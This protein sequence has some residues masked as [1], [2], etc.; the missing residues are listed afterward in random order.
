VPMLAELQI[1][2]ASAEITEQRLTGSHSMAL[3]AITHRIYRSES[4]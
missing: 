3:V 2:R 4:R 1:V